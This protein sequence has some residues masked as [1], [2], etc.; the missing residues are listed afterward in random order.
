MLIKSSIYNV[1][2]AK[3]KIK[4]KPPAS[5]QGECARGGLRYPSAKKG[6]ENTVMYSKCVPKNNFL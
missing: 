1:D 6:A 4:K 2:G 5:H 3:I